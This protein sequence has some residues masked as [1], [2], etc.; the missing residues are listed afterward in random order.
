MRNRG[1][2]VELLEAVFIWEKPGHSIGM[3]DWRIHVYHPIWAVVGVP[4]V[5]N[6]GI[7]VLEPTDV[8]RF[9]IVPRQ[10]AKVQWKRII[11]VI[12]LRS[13]LQ[14]V[15]ITFERNHMKYG[16]C[17]GDREIYVSNL[18][19]TYRASSHNKALR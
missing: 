11:P 15:E 7:F 10:E 16:V 9:G 6:V 18:M 13:F 4:D 1:E 14:I 3:S 8:F 17:V 5:D 2:R 19:E 12:V